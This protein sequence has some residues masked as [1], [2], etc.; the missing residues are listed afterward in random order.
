MA[1]WLILLVP[2]LAAL[3]FLFFGQSGE[4]GALVVYCAH[5]SLYAD[6]VLKAFEKETGIRVTTRFDTE[7]TKSLGLI[8]LIRRERENPRCDVF[9]NN[10][11]LGMLSLQKEGLLEPYQ[12][13][14]HARIPDAF[15]DPN[16]YWT[17][18]AARLRVWVGHRD[19]FP[20]LTESSIQTYLQQP[21]LSQVA[22]AKPLYGTTL[23]HY[24][25]L[26]KEMG[27]EALQQWHKQVREQGWQEVGGNAVTMRLVGE[28][29]CDL[30]WTDTDDFFVGLDAGKPLVM[31]PVR[32]PS[33]STIF[34][35]NTVALIN[36]S[37]K[38]N[39][40]RR[41]IDY[42]L[43]EQVE[44]AL[45]HSRSRQIPLG[46][47]PPG[48]LPTAVERLAAYRDDGCDLIGL[49]AERAA[50]LA[51]LKSIDARQ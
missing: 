15:K 22:M 28:G 50:C 40:A 12:G 14:G 31:S 32:T 24:V 27:A 20:E 17:G 37:K 43:S 47:V 11:L 26:W 29:V 19:R 42:L 23:T 36:G 30:G 34:I 48:S 9:W 1:R 51:W 33:G 38:K 6:E 41:L 45:A 25:L 7:A 2:A 18:F 4:D 46:P 21:D 49:E 8:E 13:L 10:E 44:L 39:R 35:P 16:G 5:D 3:G